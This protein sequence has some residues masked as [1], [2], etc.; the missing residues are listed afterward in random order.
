MK[1]REGSSIFIPPT[2]QKVSGLGRGAEIEPKF[3]EQGLGLRWL[4]EGK[5]IIENVFRFQ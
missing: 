4:L 2:K 5:K 3:I 1:S